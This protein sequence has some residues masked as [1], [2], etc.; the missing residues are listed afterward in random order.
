[1]KEFIEFSIIVAVIGGIS[2]AIGVAIVSFFKIKD[3][4]NIIFFQQITAG[5]MTGIVCFD[6]LPESFKIKNIYFSIFGVIIGIIM[7]FLLEKYIKKYNGN[8]SCNYIVSI[9]IMMSMGCHNIIEGIVIG[10]TVTISYITGVR[11]IIAIIAHDIPEGIVV[12]ISNSVSGMN[13]I[14]NTV[15]TIFIG[16]ITGFGTFIGCM[17]GDMSN[18]YK[19]LALS[20]SS[21]IMLYIVSCELI[22]NSYMK[23]K[24][25]YINISYILG[26]LI[27]FFILYM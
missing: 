13:K 18:S 27:S 12:A 3:K 21:G 10:T 26:I 14:K 15:N 20:I 25:S 9:I 5:I 24:Y 2:S 4:K 23:D 6:M 17:L 1:M 11:T 8:K 16:I 7:I 22:P 19:N